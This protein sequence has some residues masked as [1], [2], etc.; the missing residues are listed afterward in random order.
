VKMVVFNNVPNSYGSVDGPVQLTTAANGAVLAT[1]A[2]GLPGG[3]NVILA[4]VE[5]DN[6]AAGTRTVN[7]GAPGNLRLRKGTG[8]GATLVS[9]LTTVG[10]IGLETSGN[11]N[12]GTGYLL[13]AR[14]T[15]GAANQTYTVTGRASNINSIWGAVC[16]LVLQGLP[17]ANLTTGQVN[18]TNAVATWGSLATAFQRATTSFF[19][20]LNII[21]TTLPLAMCSWTDWY[22]VQ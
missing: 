16:M 11:A 8:T 19:R 10:T 9:N 18:I 6:T 5:L 22:M 2:T 7:G 13:I 17:F 3:D 20:R 21:I 4:V 1:H 15:T 14:D 12:P